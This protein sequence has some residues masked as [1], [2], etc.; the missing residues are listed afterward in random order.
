MAYETKLRRTDDGRLKAETWIPLG[1]TGKT[2]LVST[3]KTFSK[4]LRCYA[5]AVTV[6]EYG[7]KSVLGLGGDG[8]FS[9]VLVRSN[10][11]A[12]EKAILAAHNTGLAMIGPVI[13]AAIRY[14]ATRKEIA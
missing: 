9:A 7:Y 12:T 3:Y 5:H 13:D 8:D 10:N 2:L 14:Y 11:R 6:T 4:E 1:D